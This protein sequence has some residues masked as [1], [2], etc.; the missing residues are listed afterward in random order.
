MPQHLIKP[1]RAHVVDDTPC[2]CQPEFVRVCPECE[3]N[4]TDEP[5][6][7]CEGRGA[8]PVPTIEEADVVIHHG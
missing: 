8:L 7:R 2:W 5:C 6:W 4:E 3:G 1:K